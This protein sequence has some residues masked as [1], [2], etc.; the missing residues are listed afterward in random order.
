MELQAIDNLRAAEAL[1][2]ELM[3]LGLR[4]LVLCPGSRC[5]PL[6]LAA[7]RLEAHGLQLS[8]GL[9]E[10]SAAF[11]ALG[12]T[13]A[14]GAPT[15]VVTTSGT[16]VANLLP[17][18]V[19]ADLSALPLLLLT[20]DRPERL[21]HC[22]AN[23]TVNQEAFLQPACRALLQGPLAGLHQADEPRL[24]ALAQAAWRQCLGIPA[25]PV[26]LN[27][28]FDEP[29]HA[30]PAAPP[31]AAPVAASTPALQ[32]QPP[33]DC[34]PLDPDQPGVVVVG[35][36][37]RGDGSRFVA[38]LQHLVRRTGWPL[39]VDAASGLRGLPLPLVSGYDLLLSDPQ[40]VPPAAQILR[41]GS[42]PASRR[43]QT[44]LQGHTGP[45]LVITELD[46]RRQ[47]PLASGCEQHWQG[48]AS[49]VAA[50]PPGH[51]AEASLA[52]QTQWLAADAAVQQ[53]LDLELPL[54]GPCTEPALARGLQRLLPSEWPVMLASS[55]PVRD[56][57]SFAAPGER[58]RSVVS[59]RGASGIDGTLSLAAGLAS[60]WQRLV[61][62]TG[63]LALLHDSNGWLWRQQLQGQLRVV[64]IDNRGGGIF[65]QL[66]MPRAGLDFERLF[67]M[68]QAVD[69]LA[70]AAAHGVPHHDCPDLEQLPQAVQWLL[71]PDAA[72]DSMRLLRCRSD[73]A[74]DA[75]L[76]RSLRKPGWP[77][78]PPAVR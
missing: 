56:W 66:P 15:A 19:E 1:L 39:L 7:A 18:V 11:Y 65:E 31:P 55:S 68:P 54:R 58:H 76:R 14:D 46:P 43:L 42:M 8:T 40:Q 13:R 24:M 73:R 74:A 50:L 51:P 67:A 34:A 35:P 63:D 33:S 44:W 12:M 70:L 26:H 28:A 69:P 2:R 29:L 49:W 38:A 32:L 5:G 64:L 22:G 20:A 75:L 57:E 27:L 41:L 45:Q 77:A 53:R 36:W 9:D 23:Q 60:Q 78:G 48:L 6:A 59:F 21:K 47:D 62:I 17:A 4:R 10:R 52:L 37:R 25:G 61:L 71:D 72:V 16:A 3:A 30:D